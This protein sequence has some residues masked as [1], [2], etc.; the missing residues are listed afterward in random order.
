MFDKASLASMMGQMLPEIPTI[1]NYEF[2]LSKSKYKIMLSICE[3]LLRREQK[4]LIGKKR[5]KEIE[6]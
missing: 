1:S 6:N 2:L 5:P 4:Q 3:K